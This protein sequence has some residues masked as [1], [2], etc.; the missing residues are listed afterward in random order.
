MNNSLIS[1]YYGHQSIYHSSLTNRK[2]RERATKA[3]SEI[4]SFIE[5]NAIE[6]GVK[7]EFIEFSKLQDVDKRGFKGLALQEVIS[8]KGVVQK[9]EESGVIIHYRLLTSYESGANYKEW[10]LCLESFFNSD[11]KS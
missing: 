1:A 6:K 5:K 8:I 10:P 2:A 3:C 7:L 9:P 4:K 11:D